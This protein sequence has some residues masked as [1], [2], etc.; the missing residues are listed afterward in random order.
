[1]SIEYGVRI[2]VTPAVTDFS[3]GLS[4][5][6]IQW[7]TGRP[8]RSG[9]KEGIITKGSFSPVEQAISLARGGGYTTMSGFSLAIR[10]DIDGV[11]IWKIIKDLGINFIQ[12]DAEIFCW[13]D[14]VES[15]EWTGKVDN[16]EDGIDEFKFN[17]MDSFRSIHGPMTKNVDLAKFPNAPKESQGKII[18]LTFGYVTHAKALNVSS[19]S[20]SI[21][22][23]IL[24]SSN[25]KVCTATAY[26][27]TTLEIT[28]KTGRKVFSANDPL[29]VG[30]YLSV[31]KGASNLQSRKIVSNTA[32]TGTEADTG[33]T[34]IT[35][36]DAFDLGSA[37]ADTNA[38]TG[39]LWSNPHGP[40]IWWFEINSFGASLLTSLNSIERFEVNSI[41]NK[42]LKYYDKD[43]KE[44]VDVS[45]LIEFTSLSNISNLEHPGISI[46]SK[47]IDVSGDILV[48]FNIRPSQ[49]DF[50]SLSEDGTWDSLSGNHSSDK[51]NLIDADNGTSIVINGNVFHVGSPAPDSDLTLSY[52]LH[53]P[54]AAANA[55]FEGYFV[56]L[57]QT[58]FGNEKH[59]T[60][61]ARVR[62]TVKALGRDIYEANTSEIISYEII[63]TSVFASSHTT[64]KDVLPPS[65]YG[66]E[67]NNADFYSNKSNLDI[68]SLIT[69]F[70]DSV[71]YPIVRIQILLKASFSG[72]ITPDF[73]IAW[74]I[75]ELGIVGQ[76]TL[77]VVSE[78]LY[79]K[80]LGEVKKSDWDE[81]RLPGFAVENIA[82][83]IEKVF[84]EHNNAADK[85]DIDSMDDLIGFTSNRENWKIGRQY[86][87]DVN[88]F[89]MLDELAA[90][91]FLGIVAKQ[92]GK[93]A[94][95]D[96]LNSGA[97]VATHDVTVIDTDS[98]GSKEPTSLADLFNDLLIRFA[99]NPGTEKFDRFYH[100][101][102]IDEGPFP[103]IENPEWRT[104]AVGFTDEQYDFAKARWEKCNLSF[105]RYG[106][107]RRLPPELGDCHWF[108]DIVND[109]GLN[110]ANNA[111]ALYLEQGANWWPFRKDVIPYT[112]PNTAEHSSLELLDKITFNDQD[113]TA[114]EDETGWI[115][116]KTIV[117]GSGED[118]KDFI[119]IRLMLEP[120]T[121]V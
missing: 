59:A 24:G 110:E 98:I 85:L 68:Q 101:T 103:P 37:T 33:T 4:A 31:F 104:Y 54:E 20:E 105:R 11:P 65:Y 113:A 100:I 51:D 72:N 88:S 19:D 39:M 108:P 86:L 106:L 60:T 36:A 25:L 14:G 55:N 13:R 22:C 109:W 30:K 21:D 97:A 63:D 8:A 50:V 32:S 16:T 48:Y 119:E 70:K 91:A 34:V 40:Q 78:D 73:D 69:S 23:T 46:I 28:L 27:S 6:V 112:L 26:N 53:I 82:D 111:A 93:R 67:G 76:K 49:I 94:A 41:G 38:T 5:G 52:D 118:D 117:P 17:C 10:A 58:I 42:I 29:L 90:F 66:N 121:E 3:L 87:E 96:W 7:T 56:L 62:I 61:S 2:V 84:R 57:D 64:I 1:M 9:W 80:V 115:V 44:F 74:T 47:R 35:I 95:K 75:R 107:I 89:D 120:D 81:R 114:G 71:A 12:K 102:R 83:M 92:N 43:R 116:K 18:P 79:N 99:W 15:I 45:D 77:N